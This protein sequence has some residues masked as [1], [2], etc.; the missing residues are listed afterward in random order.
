MA[1]RFRRVL[2]GLLAVLV[3]TAGAV[4]VLRLSGGWD[5]MLSPGPL[6]PV[7]FAE[8]APP[9]TPNWYLVCPDGGC[10]V[11]T[12]HRASPVFAVPAAQ[13]Q[14]RVDAF[15]ASDP[16]VSVESRRNGT[17]DAV[18]RTPLMRWPDWVTLQV[19]PLDAGRSTLAVFSRSVYGVRDMGANR[20]RVEAWL[21]SLARR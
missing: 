17:I 14:D 8:L 12:A 6:R 7:V 5:R 9:T 3:V 20:A 18:V 2:T 15:L 11:G 16:A 10:P 19:I 4:G 21:D 13:M 1:Q